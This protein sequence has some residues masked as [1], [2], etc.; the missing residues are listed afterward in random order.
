MP[1]QGHGYGD[2]SEDLDVV[3]ATNL[4]YV[5]HHPPSSS[6][7]ALKMATPGSPS[8]MPA[9]AQC[10]HVSRATVVIPA[11]PH[12]RELYRQFVCTAS[13]SGTLP[14]VLASGLFSK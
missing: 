5:S 12:L 14:I 1:Y 3:D 11:T 10:S 13:S 2:S 9:S 8:N 7:P 6:E 4:T